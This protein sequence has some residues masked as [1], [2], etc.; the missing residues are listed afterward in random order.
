MP[1][2]YLL[3]RH[4]CSLC[5]QALVMIHQCELEEPISLHL[6]DID[7]Q[8]ELF[9]EYAWLVPVLIRQTDDAELKWPFNQQTLL[10]FL[11]A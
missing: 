2:F 8:Q 10:E 11:Q 3:T 1:E 4:P 9:N 6:V 7:E 5:Q